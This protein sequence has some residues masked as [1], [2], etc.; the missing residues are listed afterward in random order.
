[1]AQWTLGYRYLFKIIFSIRPEVG[2]LDHMVVLFLMS[3]GTSILPSTV[4]APV[5]IPTSS[6][7]GFT[8]RPHQH[9]PLFFLT[10]AILTGVEWYLI[11]VLI[12]IFLMV[13]DVE[14]LFTYLSAICVLSSG[15]IIYSDPCS[16]LN[17]IIWVFV[18]LLLNCRSSC[19]M[20]DINPIMGMWF[21]D[22][23]SHPVGCLFT[24]GFLCVLFSSMEFHF[25]FSFTAF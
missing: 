9:S 21:P 19:C 5:C 20:V 18:F 13:S 3:W 14:H 2:L 16:F 11:M 6:A 7:Q 23:F 17:W 4:A 10:M 15:K 12:C 1:M 22:L 25:F 8:L 24:D